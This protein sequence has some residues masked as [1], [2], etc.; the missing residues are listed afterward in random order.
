MEGGLIIWEPEKPYLESQR[1]IIM[2]YFKP[3]ILMVYFGVEWPIISSYL[4]V[5]VGSG[6]PWE[7]FS[8]LHGALFR[9][10][11]LRRVAH[12]PE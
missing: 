10:P 1:L 8:H 5:Q 12:L 9:T 6:S 11:E 4:A 2:V 3:L 7:W